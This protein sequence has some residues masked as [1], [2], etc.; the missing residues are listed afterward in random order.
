MKINVVDYFF[1]FL[2]SLKFKKI[3][4]NQNFFV[5]LGIATFTLHFVL[6]FANG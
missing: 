1:I 3:V 6:V 4:L 2:S 5:Y